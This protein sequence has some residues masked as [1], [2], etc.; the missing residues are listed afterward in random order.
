MNL[1]RRTELE[2]R[3][4]A[5]LIARQPGLVQPVVEAYMAWAAAMTGQHVYRPPMCSGIEFDDTVP[6]WHG[7][8]GVVLVVD[9]G[10]VRMPVNRQRMIRDLE[11]MDV[12]LSKI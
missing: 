4:F 6:G 12:D 1:L 10:F 11:R 5:G 7:R 8:P 3:H 2:P 9:R